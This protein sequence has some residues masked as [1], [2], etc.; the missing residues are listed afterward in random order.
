MTPLTRQQI[1]EKVYPIAEDYTIYGRVED[2][3]ELIQ[4]LT[5]LQ[6]ETW[7]AAC[8]A[9][10]KLFKNHDLLNEDLSYDELKD[11]GLIEPF[12]PQK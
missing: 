10:V 6:K 11:R 2:R 7:D 12:K 9:Q 1:A 4:L 8:K 3:R 5:T